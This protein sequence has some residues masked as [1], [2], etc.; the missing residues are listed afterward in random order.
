[1]GLAIKNHFC[2][3]PINNIDVIQIVIVIDG[4]PLSKS[5]SSQF[6]PIL[7]YIR[8]FKDSVF[9]IGLYWGHEKPQD[10]NEFLNA[11]VMETKNLLLSGIN[12]D[13]TTKQIKID[14]FCLDTPA[15]SFILKIK[16]HAGFDSC[17]RCHEEGEYLNNRT[18][19]PY[20]SNLVKRT[21]NDYLI[22]KY[23]EHHVGNTI[24]ILSELL[25]NIIDSFGLDY[26]HLTCLGV[27]RKLL[28]LWINNG[29]L[30]VRL[31]SSVSKQLSS[32]LLNLRTY[33]PCEFSRKPRGV[34][35]LSRFKA[36]ELRQL[37]I[38][39]GQIIFK[40][41]LNADCYK[42]FMALNISMTILLSDNMDNYYVEYA[43]NLL[44]YFVQNFEMI[45]SR[46]LMSYNVHG[47]LHISD[48]YKHF[49]ALDNISAFPFENYLKSLK[50][51]VRKHDKPLQQIVKR[52]NERNQIQGNIS[53]KINEFP[54][55]KSIHTEGPLLQNINGL[56]YKKLYLKNITIKVDKIADSFFL[57]KTF[58]VV[59]V[60]NIVTLNSTYNDIIIVGK[61]FETKRAF[62]ESPISSTV[63]NIYEVDDL[64]YSYLYWSFD[65]IKNKVMMI[66]WDSK[67]IAIPII[68]S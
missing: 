14:D 40:K 43:R 62:Y 27:M 6:W 51:M 3:N 64:S 29:P 47:L 59:K 67:K 66:E 65:N 33:I 58:D 42:H 7:G 19:F 37:L 15:K 23:E 36:T 53:K 20:S 18:C 57:T 68:H 61:V 52:F 31:Q 26:M 44:N 48:D 4:L 1:L 32:S 30:N 25:I 54:Y 63:F 22:R 8:P 9:I 41:Y 10:S 56:Q 50:K 13:G 5:S 28:H 21:H 55:L 38:Y 34:N 2:L 12:I 11:F 60:Y 45:Y 24:S 39:T 16:G 35:E 49:G 17:T 46:H